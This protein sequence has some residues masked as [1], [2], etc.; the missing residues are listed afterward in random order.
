MSLLLEILEK[1]QNGETRYNG[2]PFFNA[3]IQSLLKGLGVYAVLDKVLREHKA[4]RA[5]YELERESNK[6]LTDWN[7]RLAERLND[8]EYLIK[9]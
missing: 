2:D 9:S 5:A 7:T 3:A 6:R 1:F 4:L 8:L